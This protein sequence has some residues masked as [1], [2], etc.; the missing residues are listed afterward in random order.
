MKF[1]P[2]GEYLASGGEDG[3]VRIWR[4]ISLD[5]STALDSFISKVTEDISSSWK[6]RSS[7]PH[8]F[9]PKK[10]LQLEETPLHEFYGH[11]SDILD[12]AW[13]NSDILLSASMDKTVRLWRV[14]CNQCLSVFP[15]KDYVTCI[16]FNPVDENYFISGS[17]D[18]KVRVW[19]TYE[20]RVVDW[21][22]ARD[23]ITAISYQP[24][25]KG[26]IVGSLTG[27]CRFYV[28]SGKYFQ[29][30]AQ[31]DIDGKKKTAGN[32]ITGIQFSQD[33]HQRV[34]I[35]SEDSKLRILDGINVVQKYRGL[36]KSGSQMSGSFTCSGRHIISVGEDCRVYAWNYREMENASLKQKKSERSCE[37]FFSEGVTVAVPWSAM[38]REQKISQS[39][40][41]SAHCRSEMQDHICVRELERFSFG[42][43]FSIDATCRVST[44]WPEEKLPIWDFPFREGEYDQHRQS[45][46]DPCQCHHSSLSETWGL[47]IV[48]A[49]C[50]GT[51]KTFHNLGLPVRL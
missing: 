22:D 50:D 10:V 23:V 24:D 9:L 14:G 39:P 45:A 33:K 40:C 37:Y 1:S 48:T 41:N 51:I 44:T 19:G 2:N 11:S 25:G 46:E 29:L 16:Q 43:W 8:I 4:V 49:D 31:I 15:H 30:E 42:N 36:P 12:L 5:T 17:I 7:Q 21:A 20:G 38:T 47:S 13:F 26:F 6:K 3:V 28:A 32:K 35:S 34:M 18:G 27:T